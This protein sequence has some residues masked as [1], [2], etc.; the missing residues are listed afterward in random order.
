MARTAFVTGANGFIGLNLIEE[1]LA[2]GWSVVAMHRADSDIETLQGLDVERVIGDVTDS[3]TLRKVMPPGIDA[4]FHVAGLTTLWSRRVAEQTRVN[5][6]GTRNMVRVALESGAGRFVHTSSVVA[7]GLHTGTVTEETPTRGTNAP[8]NYVRSKA[9][10]EREVRRGIRR[11]LDAVIINPANVLGPHD[12][13]NWSRLFRLTQQHRLPGMPPGGGSFCHSRE[14]A[15]AMVSAVDKGET[16]AN[17]LL[18]G[19]NASYVKLVHE[20]AALMGRRTRY[21]PLPPR[22]LRTYARVEE[23]MASIFGREPDITTDSIRL[24]SISLY[25][26]SR[27]AQAELGYQPATLDVLLEDCYRWMVDSGRLK[28]PIS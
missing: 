12:R 19:S 16:G 13:G 8:I 10:A 6:K 3:R 18:G 15:R 26:S 28:P 23:L 4:V 21:R 5:V 7:Y 2:Q 14:V 25:C 20:M 1:L 22:L 17:Y 11:G 9:L 24:L 27:K